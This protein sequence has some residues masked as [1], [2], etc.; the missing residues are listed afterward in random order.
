MA[1]NLFHMKIDRLNRVEEKPE[2]GRQAFKFNLFEPYRQNRLTERKCVARLQSDV[3]RFAGSAAQEEDE[4]TS[5]A[6]PF[7]QF[8]E[9]IRSAGNAMIKP[10]G[11]AS[12]FKTA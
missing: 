10:K 4:C 6:Q 12:Q 2:T 5:S 3:S 8:T 1:D 11:K 9:P 7:L